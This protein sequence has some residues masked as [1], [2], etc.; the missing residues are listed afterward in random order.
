[1]VSVPSVVIA[2][3]GFVD[4]NFVRLI[5]LQSEYCPWSWQSAWGR[6][7]A[8][9]GSSAVA[10]GARPSRP[11]LRIR[12][13]AKSDGAASCWVTTADHF[14]GTGAADS[15]SAPVEGGTSGSFLA[16]DSCFACSGL[17]GCCSRSRWR[18][19]CSA[20]TAPSSG[21]AGSCGDCAATD[22]LA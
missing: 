15:A 21:V 7:S 9:V 16:S 4:G 20:S 13:A 11:S 18:E 6:R 14:P 17:L 22:F 5:G 10:S 2:F 12:E 8:A 1:M 19:Q 3:V